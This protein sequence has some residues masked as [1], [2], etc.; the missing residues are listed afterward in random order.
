MV[1]FAELTYYLQINFIVQNIQ[2]LIALVGIVA[3]LL[4]IFVFSQNT[5]TKY[6]YAFFA[7]TMA[8]ND[9][10]ILLHALRRWFRYVLGLDVR[11]NSPF[12]CATCR[13]H[14]YLAGYTSLWLL[15]LIS[16][17]RF[18]SIVYYNRYKIFTSR[19]FQFAM[20]IVIVIYSSLI[21]LWFPLSYTLEQIQINETNS[22]KLVCHLPMDVSETTA[23]LLL[24][25]IFLVNIVINNIMNVKILHFMFTSRKKWQRAHCCSRSVRDRKFAFNSIVH[26]LTSFVSKLPMVLGALISAYFAHGPQQTELV[27]TFSVT[28]VILNHSASFFVNM[29]ANS[30]FYKE[31]LKILTIKPASLSPP[32]VRAINIANVR[33]NELIPN[34]GNEHEYS[35]LL[36][37]TS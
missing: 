17:D 24:I 25:N 36:K 16:F 14:A 4:T 37:Y 13:Y 1:K 3:N 26:N 34:I 8:L 28:I 18:H 12:F 31:F 23:W 33:G 10:I 15:V 21:N 5:L 20:V 2:G 6:S 11:L 32:T 9:I 22:S 29:L 27:Y 30:I 35:N 19:L 7:R